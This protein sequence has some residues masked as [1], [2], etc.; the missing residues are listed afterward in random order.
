MTVKSNY[1]TAIATLVIGLKFSRQFF[2]ER[3]AKLNHIAHCAC[4]LP[5]AL[6]KLQVIT[7]NS[8]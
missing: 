2:N 7:T 3:E 6:R 1:A 4:N 5:R 8:D